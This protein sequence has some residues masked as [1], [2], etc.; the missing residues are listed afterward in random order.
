MSTGS[1]QVTHICHLEFDGILMWLS[2]LF[3]KGGAKVD[4]GSGVIIPL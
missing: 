4:H 1:S 2:L 3:Q